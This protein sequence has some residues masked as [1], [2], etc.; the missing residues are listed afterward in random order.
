VRHE[1][2]SAIAASLLAVVLAA[3][4][5]A[6]GTSSGTSAGAADS[7]P[8]ST[9]QAQSESSAR[10][11]HHT[12]NQTN[13]PVQR[14]GAAGDVTT[15]AEAAR[16]ASMLTAYN[17]VD[18]LKTS[19]WLSHAGYSRSQFGKAWIDVDGN[20]CDT[21]DDILARDLRSISR[22]GAC[23]VL[24]GTL[25]DPYTGQTIYYV[26][27]NGSG[28]D[29]D[30]VVALS[31]AWET[32]AAVWAYSKRAALANDPANL[33]AVDASA[34]RQKGDADA[35]AWLP[36]RSYQCAYVARQVMV[37]R[38]YQLF[39]TSD[40]KSAMKRVLSRC[41]SMR[42]PTPGS[43]PT[44]AANAGAPPLS[45]STAV[46]DTNASTAHAGLDP[47]F[48][49]CAKAKAAGYGPYVRGRD[50]EYAWYRDGDRDGIDCE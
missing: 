28:V 3:C 9:S 47:R 20:H 23:K 42:L 18:T 5:Q 50:S 26:R 2:R 14:H 44:T 36:Q 8:L 4:N 24:S 43:Q 6:S 30:H 1:R 48:S 33:L 31:N 12:D 19:T 27:G 35:G 41:S 38:K 39:V 16:A 32:G 45:S 13:S 34:N 15:A 37:K 7:V 25:P 46:G 49:S 21:R 22:A 11:A 29:I 10:S 40:E 17:A